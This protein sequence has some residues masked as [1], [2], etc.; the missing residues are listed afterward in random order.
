MAKAK[1]QTELA[2][3]PPL[4]ITP[5][6]PTPVNGNFGELEKVLVKWQADM[7]KLDIT[8]ENMELVRLV[9]S[10]ARQRRT[11]LTKIK[12]ENNRI[13]F[14]Q[15]KDIYSKRMDNLIALVTK[16]EQQ[17][18]KVLDKEE[19]ERRTNIT[20][21]LDIYR[22]QFQKKYQLHDQFLIR[23]D[24]R[25][26]YYNKTADEKKRKDD[27]E[28]QFK[29]LKKA[30][31]E[32]DA[33]FRFVTGLCKQDPRL[34]VQRYLR[35]LS[36]DSTAVIS[37]Q[38]QQEI[39]RLKEVDAATAAAAEAP[40]EEDQDGDGTEAL[41]EAADVA[42]AEAEEVSEKEHTVL[43]VISNLNFATDFPGRNKTTTIELTYPCDMSPVLT[44]LFERLRRYGIKSRTVKEPELVKEPP[45]KRA[46]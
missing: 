1:T 9:K 28:Q 14:N 6:R 11:L 15:P 2:V 36:S 7:L 33:G 4:V 20:A 39:Q 31:D 25:K 12:D 32:Y 16:V 34:D 35:M 26:D 41:P 38:I 8:E 37:E 42:Y 17:A 43:G 45:R 40:P 5:E 46:S 22:G 23:V 30:Q 18:D 3:L 21:L 19:E 13:F 10:T 29:D 27:L 44:E 24:Y